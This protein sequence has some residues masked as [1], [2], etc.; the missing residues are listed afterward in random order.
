MVQLNFFNK[1]HSLTDT[2]MNMSA[3]IA[4]QSQALLQEHRHQLINNRSYLNN[5]KIFI[6]CD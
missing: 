3:L 2:F 1:A 5:T 4:I 6:Y